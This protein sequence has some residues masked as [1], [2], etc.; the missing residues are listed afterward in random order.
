MV[1]GTWLFNH[2]NPS[3]GVQDLDN[4]SLY[5]VAAQEEREDVTLKIG[6]IGGIKLRQTMIDDV[7]SVYGKPT[8]QKTQASGVIIICMAWSMMLLLKFT[9][10]G[11]IALLQA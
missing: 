1:I 2:A 3:D 11:K 10:I 5:V 9:T 6:T 7:E 4:Q 8:A